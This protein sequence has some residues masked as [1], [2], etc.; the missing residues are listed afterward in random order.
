MPSLQSLLPCGAILAATLLAAFPASQ[1]GAA[2]RILSKL[3]RGQWLV[4]PY[5]KAAAERS[6]CVRDAAALLQLEHA[7]SCTREL[8][9]GD[10]RGATIEYSCGSRGFGRT[11]IT[12]QTPRSA[13]ID[14]QGMLDGKPFGYR[15]VA[16]KVHA[17]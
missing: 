3:E 6:L 1:G 10:S 5:D 17:C 15:A 13:T 12:L 11:A 8:V 14:T 7:G 4:K 9:S 16:R 2:A